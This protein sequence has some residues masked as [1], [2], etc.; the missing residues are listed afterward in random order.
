VDETPPAETQERPP[1]RRPPVDRYSDLRLLGAS[2]VSLLLGTD[3]LVVR[4]WFEDGTLPCL[5]VGKSR[6][7]RCTQ[8]ML[9]AWQD[10]LGRAVARQLNPAH[11]LDVD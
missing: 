11:V 10:E 1:E 6:E 7:P 5:R 3:A 2:E 4:A 8:A 9:R